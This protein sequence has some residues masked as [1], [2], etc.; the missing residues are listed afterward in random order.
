[1][2]LNGIQSPTISILGILL[3]L[4]D[5]LHQY[6]SI[7]QM[8]ILFKFRCTMYKWMQIRILHTYVVCSWLPY[9][10]F[11]SIEHRIS[12]YTLYVCRV[13]FVIKTILYL[14][15]ATHSQ[16]ESKIYEVKSQPICSSFAVWRT[17]QPV[18]LWQFITNH[19][20]CDRMMASII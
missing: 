14:F 7:Y 10:I 5:V 19:T 18:Q 8:F 11:N 12:T 20:P 6:R 16:T 15:L 17:S 3:A 13:E 1:M 9:L 2:L 4:N